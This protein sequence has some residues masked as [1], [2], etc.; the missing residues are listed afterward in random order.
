MG[1]LETIEHVIQIVKD[2]IPEANY[3]EISEALVD[4][5]ACVDTSIGILN[6]VLEM[7]KMIEG[8]DT[9]EK[10]PTNLCKF[11]DA[12]S[13][14]FYGKA[15]SKGV[16]FDNSACKD[17]KNIN[18]IV[19]IDPSKMARVIRNFISNALKF[20]R[21]GGSIQINVDTFHKE[22]K[23]K[24]ESSIF[25][26]E[27]KF[28]SVMPE[29]HIDIEAQNDPPPSH[30]FVRIEVKDTGI[31]IAEENIG[32]IFN[33]SIQIDF[34]RNQG[35]GGSGLG[36][37]IAKKIVEE[38]KGKVGVTSEGLNH[39]SCFYFEIPL[40]TPEELNDITSSEYER[41]IGEVVPRVILNSNI[42]N[43]NNLIRESISIPSSIPYS[44]DGLDCLNGVETGNDN[45]SFMPIENLENHNI[46]MGLIVENV[47][48]VNNIQNVLIVE[49]SRVCAKS[50]AKSIERLGKE[51]TIVENGQLAV[52]EI[53]Q[54]SEKYDLILMD[55][56]M[57]VMKGGEAAEKIR[58]LR[59]VNPIIGLTGNLL[60]EDVD[61]FLKNGANRVIGKPVNFNA[62]KQ[63]FEEFVA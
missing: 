55:N 45:T 32:K 36:L 31:G 52:D 46:E 18:T 61:E 25:G 28:S 27:F 48:N 5:K 47:T 24:K 20:T 43:R 12:A 4:S 7:D 60:Q 59:Y 51:Y 49:D 33:Q 34:Y 62:L 13:H 53:E 41:L 15:V 40:A 14:I 26:S 39:G 10:V 56:L 37:L 23:V 50:L 38:H 6:D 11:I 29:D 30:N 58:E 2:K 44:M 19:M 22:K 17:P 16:V 35:G 57:P 63:L 8:Q 9:Y 1:G 42:S 21:T 54:N 3:V